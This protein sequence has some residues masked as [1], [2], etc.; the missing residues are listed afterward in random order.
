MDDYVLASQATFDS[1]TMMVKLE[2]AA[3]AD[4]TDEIEAELELED[5]QETDILGDGLDLLT[6]PEVWRQGW[7]QLFLVRVQATVT[8]PPG[9]FIY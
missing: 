5:I 7:R 8:C 4:F 2:F 9:R 6:G 3:W 1:S